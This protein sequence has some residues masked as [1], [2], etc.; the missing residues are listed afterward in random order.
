MHKYAVQFLEAEETRDYIFDY[1]KAQFT[2]VRLPPWGKRKRKK[3]TRC[4]YEI[5][6]WP[7][8][9]SL[10]VVLKKKKVGGDK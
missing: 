2:R 6:D 7:H 10:R 4:A 9:R 1:R 8:Q 5:V 3:K